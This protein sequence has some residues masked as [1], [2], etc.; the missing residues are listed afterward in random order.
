MPAASR[1]FLRIRHRD[2]VFG[3]AM[4]RFL[5]NPEAALASG[6]RVVPDLIYG[7]GSDWS[8]LDEYLTA[9]VS[10]ALI[11]NGPIL[12]CGSGLTTI[13]V[14]AIAKKRNNTMWS[15]EHLPEWAER[16]NKYTRKY[17]IDS[18][19]ISVRPLKDYRDFTWYDPPLD[20]MPDSFALVICDGPP[21]V[22]EELGTVWQQ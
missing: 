15:L 7:W 16:V 13:L 22:R 5:R 18:V 2:F 10:H 12:E 17:D 4:N 19:H 1:R 8:A 14:G 11:C 9:C 3:R 6:S 20:S 21:G